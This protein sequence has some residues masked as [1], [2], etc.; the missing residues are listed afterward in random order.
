VKAAA[1]FANR[2]LEDERWARQKLAA[3][4]GRT[5]RIDIGPSRVA[6]VIDAEGRFASSAGEPDL[7]VTIPPLVLPAL[8]G[9]PSRWSELVSAT[10]DP[11]LAA[12]LAELAPTLPW[13]VERLLSKA[14]GPIAGQQLADAAR[15]L[16]RLPGYAA[17]RVNDSFARYVADEGRLA[18]GRS[19]ARGFADELSALT[20]R[21]D[22]LVERVN[23]LKT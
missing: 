20:A 18:A 17:E 5:L 11:A 4:A 1:D 21:V 3:H 6:V 7:V 15:Y 23:R 14:L 19:E 9:E 10:G 22:A 13:F 16:L 8:L 2:A 12:T